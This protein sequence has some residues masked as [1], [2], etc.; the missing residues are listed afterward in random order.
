MDACQKMGRYLSEWKDQNFVLL[1]TTVHTGHETIKRN[2]RR[3]PKTATNARTSRAI[4]GEE[5]VKELS[6]PEFI[7]LYNH[8]MNGVDIAD[9][10]RSYYSTQR[11]HLENWK[12]LWH[13]LLDTAVTNAYKIGYCSPERP[14]AHHHEY[15]THREFRTN[16]VIQLYEHSERLGDERTIPKVGALADYAHLT[17]PFEHDEPIKIGGFGYCV[18][19]LCTGR[20]AIGRPKRKALTKLSVNSL[21]NKQRRHQ[22][23]PRSLYG[24]RLCKVHLCHNEDC[25]KVHLD[26][27]NPT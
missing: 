22:R 26:A 12:P 21:R 5:A 27:A 19:C 16:L 8:F 1:M 17:P 24:C 9:Q 3:S 14:W 7:D 23:A 2:R 15:H 6:I 4:F 10:I 18:V 20:S 11:V 25:W 13:F